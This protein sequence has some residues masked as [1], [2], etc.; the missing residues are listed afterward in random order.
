VNKKEFFARINKHGPKKR[1]MA[2]R[3]WLW[4]A[5]KNAAGY[6]QLRYEGAAQCAHRVSWQVRRGTIPGK[7]SVL[8][9]CDERA[10]VRPGHLFLGTQTDNMQDAKRK[11]RLLTPRGDRNGSSLHPESRAYG[12]RNGQ[13][14]LTD[15]AVRE[16]RRKHVSGGFTYAAL[17]KYYGCTQSN[18]G[19]IIRGKSRTR[20][21]R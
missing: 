12:E 1:Y 3:C 10:C 14:V 9:K 19:C 16:I 13:A 4:T 15:A 11:G 2:T 6:G 7:L 8:H 5:G 21:P 17:G 18:I 20:G